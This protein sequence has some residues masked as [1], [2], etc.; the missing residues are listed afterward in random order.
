MVSTE[1][2]LI[3]LFSAEDGKAL[4]SQQKQEWELT[5]AQIMNSLLQNS[6][7]NW[8]DLNKPYSSILA[9]RIPG[10]G[11]WW[12][13]VYG[14]Y[15]ELDM[16]DVTWQQQQTTGQELSW[17]LGC[18]E[19]ADAEALGVIPGLGRSP[20]EGNGHRFQDSCLRNPMDWEPC[21]L[22]SVEWMW[23]SDWAHMHADQTNLSACR[24]GVQSPK[25]FSL[26]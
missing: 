19:P 16:T 4:Y 1:I 23:L 18:E 17:W 8:S 22:L 15:G 26:G 10:T 6:D 13:A 5:V 24:P 9:W 20:G 21:W 25:C 3:I 14:V 2:R 7:L 12:A 11:A